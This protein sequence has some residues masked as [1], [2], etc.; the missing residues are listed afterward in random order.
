MAEVVVGDLINSPNLPKINL[1]T[2]DAPMAMPEREPLRITIG[3]PLEQDDDVEASYLAA[4]KDANAPSSFAWGL[5]AEA[6]V[7]PGEAV[8]NKPVFDYIETRTDGDQQ[9]K[10]GIDRDNP[11]KSVILETLDFAEDVGAGLGKGA[12]KGLQDAGTELGDFMTNGFWS[13]TIT[14][15]M[16]ENVPY[17]DEA[18]KAAAEALKPEGAVQEVTAAFTAPMAQVVAPGSIFT[19]TF[20]A[21]GIST[22]ILA[23]TLGYSAAEIAAVDPKDATLMEL[24]LQLIDDDP[25]IKNI[26][27]QAF[28]AQESESDFMQRVKN[29]PRKIV[30]GG[31]TGVIAER[32]FD[33]IGMA[34]RAMKNSRVVKEAAQR[35]AEGKSPI[36]VGMSI[37]DVGKGAL[38]DFDS[39]LKEVDPSNKVIPSE[40]RPN[41]RMGDM[42]GMLPKNAEVVQELDNGVTL[43][44]AS[45]GDYYATAYNPD[46]GSEDVVGYILGRENGTELAVVEEMQGKG[47]GSELQYMFRSENPFAPTSGLTDAGKRRL[48]QTY[49]RLR[50]DGVFEASEITEK[51]TA[52]ESPIITD[53]SPGVVPVSNG[54][55]AITFRQQELP[56]YI[57]STSGGKVGPGDIGRYWDE[58]YI[59]RYGRQGDPTNQAD[60]DEAIEKAFSEA[61]F[62]LETIDTGKGWY[63]QDIKETW[64]AAGEIFP[65]LNDGLVMPPNRNSTNYAN[66]EDVSAHA[67]RILTTAIAAPLSFGNRPKPNFNAA[68][69]VLDGWMADGAIPHMNPETG[70]L[71]TM[72]SV[73]SESLR[74]LQHMVDNLGVEGTAE[75]LMSPHTVREI[76]DARRAAG[77]WKD[78]SSMSVPGKMDEQKLG[79]FSLGRKGGP[80]FLNLNGIEDTTADLWFTRTWN[81][82][83]GRMTSPNLP[84]NEVILNQPRATERG[85]MKEWNQE[86]AAKLGE[87][88]QDSQAILW[89]FEQQLFNSMGQASAKPSKFSD[90]AKEFRDKGERGRYGKQR[91]D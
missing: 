46:V 1:P 74:F 65:E 49:D 36:P 33:A 4:R 58:D 53:L 9:F 37:E 68:L 51:L 43:Y 32:T 11:D 52:T 83:F 60:M 26:V 76:R 38:D 28:A 50:D 13:S 7:D 59:A 3:A 40:N 90:G 71:W 84:A 86:V 91:N 81:R 61:N 54:S 44:R 55:P 75:W 89:Y 85:M 27:E 42:Y 62:Q 34:Y 22:R 2:L 48:E 64:D 18:N 47:I 23:E 56:T 79:A 15:W 25:E 35:S 57:P 78:S 67:L 87:T 21:A 12:V 19:R 41:L 29:M 20:R 14:P 77:V 80:F 39:Y 72:R 69:K 30:E 66:G 10:V 45:N 24:G 70:K 63:D 6:G 8:L 31:V 17:L 88:E 16:Q 82:Q 73:S 5:A